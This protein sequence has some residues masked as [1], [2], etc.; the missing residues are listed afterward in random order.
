MTKNPDPLKHTHTVY[1]KC[2]HQ[3]DADR[4]KTLFELPWLERFTESQ[5]PGGQILDL[6]CGSGEP[7][8]EYLIAQG[9]RV[10]GLDFSEPLLAL[11]RKRFPRHTWMHGDIRNLDLGMTFDGILAW[12]SL[13]HLT[14]SD[15]RLAIPRILAHLRSGGRFMATVTPVAGETTG[16]AG[17]ESV[18][19]GGLSPEEYRSLLTANGVDI[20]A[21]RITDPDCGGATIVLGTKL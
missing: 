5:V 4:T 7:M 1:E 17:G 10:S 18:Y 13:F 9:Y 3:F 19:H 14:P 2:A 21:F 15:Q 6:G 12:H 8:A 20:E 16:L 11:A